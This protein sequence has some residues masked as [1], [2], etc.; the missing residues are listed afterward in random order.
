MRLL[1]TIKMQLIFIKLYLQL[2]QF[3]APNTAVKVIYKFIS[4]PRIRKRK[5][6]DS[7][8][9]HSAIKSEIVCDHFQVQQYEWNTSSNQTILLI[10][11]WEGQ[12]SNFE[13]LIADLINNDYHVIAIDAPAH[14]ES[15]RVNTHMFEFGF[16]LAKQLKKI[17]PQ[18][19]IS[20][21]FGSVSIAMA[22][23]ENMD[24]V[25]DRWL[26]VTTAYF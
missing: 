7:K 15:K 25:V 24:I 17:S 10:H 23:I 3:F 4:T 22:L 16:F 5:H 20:H 13:P 11:G 12:T 19:L 18:F 26:L 9:M 2:L 14:G 21:S 8:I 6:E 1:K